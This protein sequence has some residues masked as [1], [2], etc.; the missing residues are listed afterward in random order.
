MKKIGIM[1]A[2]PEE[3]EQI[4]QRMHLEHTH[5]IANRQYYT[6]KGCNDTALVVV[7]SRWGKVAAASTATTLIQKFECDFIIFTGVAG[8]L[9]PNLN[10]G[11]IVVGSSLV[12]HDMNASPFFPPC[13]IPLTGLI[14]FKSLPEH[15]GSAVKAA[16]LFLETVEKSISAQELNQFSISKPKVRAGIIATGDQFV[17][18]KEDHTGL[19]FIA[20]ENPCAVEMEGAAV[21]QV[22]HEH[23]VPFIVFRTISDK[24]DHSAHIDFPAFINKIAAQ[25]ASGIVELFMSIKN[26]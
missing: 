10:I 22:C 13:E 2:M 18:N 9:D 8:A 3:I 5:D 16:E 26:Q 19:K 12:Q 1:G 7:F 14:F 17:R 25:Y 11:D 6:G 4:K 24:A 15:V 21:A 23:N 20:N